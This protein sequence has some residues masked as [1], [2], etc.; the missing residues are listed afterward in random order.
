MFRLGARVARDW[1]QAGRDSRRDFAT[2]AFPKGDWAPG[3]ATR[4]GEWD[5]G[6]ATRGGEAGDSV[7]RGARAGS[8]S[9]ERVGARHYRVRRHFLRGPFLGSIVKQR[10]MKP[11]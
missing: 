9:A 11:R 5:H 8:H 1:E 4:R 10:K 6:G 3:A 7:R 2:G